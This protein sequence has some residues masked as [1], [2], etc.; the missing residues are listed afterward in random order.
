MIFWL[1]LIG[2]GLAIWFGKSRRF[3]QE[4]APGTS[5]AGYIILSVLGF[6]LCYLIVFAALRL[7]GAN[8]RGVLQLFAFLQLG[9]LVSAVYFAPYLLLKPITIRPE[10]VLAAQIHLPAP[11]KDSNPKVFM[12]ALP[13]IAG[14]NGSELVR[15]RLYDADRLLGSVSTT[16][17]GGKPLEFRALDQ[18]DQTE[19]PGTTN[20]DLK[21]FRTG[22]LQGRLELEADGPIKLSQRL[23]TEIW[24]LHAGQFSSPVT[25]TLGGWTVRRASSITTDRALTGPGRPGRILG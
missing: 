4:R 8:Q 16:A 21:A 17:P 15:V 20:V 13:L 25:L 23:K 18:P 22:T 11:P 6:V 24:L 14:A 12:V 1:W 2:L 5:A 9:N 7:G 19:D 3:S 10:D